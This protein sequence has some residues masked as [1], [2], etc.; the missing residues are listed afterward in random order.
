MKFR[1]CLRRALLLI[2][3]IDVTLALATLHSATCASL[4]IDIPKIDFVTTTLLSLTPQTENGKQ[5]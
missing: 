1:I 4:P 5:P 3:K 2:K